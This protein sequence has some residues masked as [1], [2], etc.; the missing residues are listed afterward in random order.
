MIN[1]SEQ[2]IKKY[3]KDGFI[4]K[5]INISD[6]DLENCIKSAQRTRSHAI[7]IGYQQIRIYQDYL[8]SIKNISGIENIFCKE[9][10]DEP[11]KEL[12]NNLSL[13]EE[14]KKISEW[15]GAICTVARLFC[16]K[17]EYNY[18]GHW[19]KD[20]EDSSKA[21]QISLCLK[22]E[23]G[24]KI[25]KKDIKNDYLKT[26]ST[27]SL[28]SP[29]PIKIE[30]KYFNE[31]D[32]KAGEILFFEPNLLHQGYYYKSRLTYHMKFED[33]NRKFTYGQFDNIDFNNKLKYD[34][35]ISNNVDGTDNTFKFDSELKN[36]FF[37]RLKKIINYYVPYGNLKC[38]IKL[39]KK[40]KNQIKFDCFANTYWQ[41]YI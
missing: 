3:K 36:S 25:F 29:L 22:D 35:K 28:E 27:I 20:I 10:L 34:F 1:L 18:A 5:K 40:Y 37:F 21:I 24:F 17:G 32:L 15:E 31:L 9:I 11:I 12:F 30:A 4:I 14:I 6:K 13:G 41:R 38:L 2:D 26:W 39:N 8:S 7:E 19:H 23:K 33:I 16:Q